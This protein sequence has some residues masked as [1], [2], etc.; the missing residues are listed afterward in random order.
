VNVSKNVTDVVPEKWAVRDG[1]VPKGRYIDPEFL[2]LEHERLFSQVWQVAC[3]EEEVPEPGSFCEYTIGPES[4]LVVRQQDG[5]LKALHNVCAHRGMKIISGAGTV[6]EFRC[7]FHGWRYDLEGSSTFVPCRDEFPD[8]PEGEWG[9]QPV[10]VGTWGGWVFVSM[11]EDPEPLLE[12]LDP[13]PTALAP[14]R[15]EDMRFRWRKRTNLPA[16]WKVLLDA[17]IEGYHAAGTHPQ[18]LRHGD[19]V[20]PSHA[21]ATVEEYASA[22]YNPSVEYRNHSRF[23]Y[24]QRPETAERDAGR[25]NNTAAAVFY[26]NVMQYQHLEVGSLATERDARAAK[27]LTTMDIGEEEPIIVYQRLCE[28]L[29]VA[30]GVDFPKMTL[31]EY[32]AGNGDW[33]VVPT[34]VI[35]VE[36]TCVLGYRSRPHAED[37]N[38]CVWE[39]FS[40]EHFSKDEVPSSKWQVFEHWRDDDHWGKLPTQDLKNLPDVQAGMHSS[41]FQGLW[42]NAAQEGAVRNHH[43][44]A[45]RFIFGTED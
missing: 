34:L 39:M 26:G 45:D 7:R 28:E 25:Q 18:V 5:S 33:H 6:P 12:W 36:K 4:I 29:A 3:R 38:Q 23:I 42:L 32:F 44:I 30:E 37:P 9:L 10:H 41:G 40:L 13:L 35:L 21:P 19:G 24:S 8:R 11:A 20:Y 14:F 2:K 22:P 15:L 16:N 43:V 1:F 17:F 31:E 27:A